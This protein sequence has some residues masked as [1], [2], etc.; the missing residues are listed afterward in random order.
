MHSD[1]LH[2]SVLLQE[3]VE[4]LGP[5]DG[6][7]YLDA[8]FGNGGY[9][10]A[11]LERADCCVVA[12]DRDPD[13]IRRGIAMQQEFVGRFVLVEGCFSDMASLI[14]NSPAG[15]E[16]LRDGAPEKLDGAA[17]DLGV[18]STQLDQADRGFSFRFDGPLDMR[19]SKSGASAADI[20][21]HSDAGDLAQILWEYGE[22]KASRR[23]ARAIVTARETTP[24]T[25]TTQLANIIYSVM[26]SKKPGQID[27]ATRS[28]QAL[29][30]FVNRELDE[31]ADGLTAIESLLK[32]ES[33][34]AVVS[35]H[36]LEDR[37]VKHFLT[38]R[39][40]HAARPSRHVPVLT[41]TTPS[42]DLLARKA[43]LPG[44]DER[45]ANSRAR[46]A[47]LRIARRTTAPPYEPIDPEN[48]ACG[49]S[50]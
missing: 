49:S 39:S 14:K 37:I 21:M 6:H 20:V 32:P 35:F 46:S 22:E 43:I 1:T 19:M 29:R 28:F 8:T 42:F 3:V 18:C 12:I 44:K 40:Q 34:L 30:I 27:P 15:P 24:I 47:K 23:I 26:P 17:F 11:L 16:M 7:F 45:C 5:T 48:I 41:H 4:A 2:H 10:R 31:L 13:A 38:K 36:S 25:S 50:F 33:V 9:S